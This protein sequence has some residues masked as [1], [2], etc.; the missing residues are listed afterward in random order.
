MR[1]LI[2]AC[3]LTVSASFSSGIFAAPATHRYN[4]DE[5]T[6]GELMDSPQTRAV[7][8]KYI[9]GLTSS[10]QIELAKGMTLTGIQPFAPDMVTDDALKKIDA[11]LA[12]VP[13]DNK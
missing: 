12:K 11:E 2:F 4:V 13:A 10:D 7:L 5:S 6:I 3:A 8:D 1:K 9:P